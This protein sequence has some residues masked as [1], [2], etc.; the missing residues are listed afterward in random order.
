L[1]LATAS[2]TAHA[3]E[4]YPRAEAAASALRASAAIDAFLSAPAS[5]AIVRGIDGAEGEAWIAWFAG[6]AF[7]ATAANA[8][9][10]RQWSRVAEIARQRGDDE[11]YGTA[12]ARRADIAMAA[13][14]YA[15][16]EELAVTLLAL[17]RS[18]GDSAH[19]AIAEENL[20]VLER[21]RGHLDAA[22]THQLRALQLHRA[23]NDA[24]GAALALTN[25]ATLNRDRGDFAQALD[26]ALESVA[27]RERSGDRLEIA[28]RNAALLYREIE[29]AATSRSYFQRAL[30]IAARKGNPSTYSP[31]IGAYAG[32]LNDLGEFAAAQDAAGEA[33]AIDQALGDRP[34]QGLEHLELGRALIGRRQ[35]DAASDELDAALALGRELGQREIVASALLHLAD[36]ALMRHDTLHAR[37]LL[38][39][40]ISGLEAAQLRTQLAHAYASREQLARAEHNDTD[41][42]RFAH[43]HAAEREELLG[44]R[45]SRQLAALETRHAR[46]EAEQRLAL[47][48]KNNE[49]QAALLEKQRLQRRVDLGALVA[50]GALLLLLIWRFAGISRLNRALAMRNA[51]IEQQRSTLG[52]ANQ[53]LERQAIDLYQVAITD[54]MTGV[55]NRGHI[56]QRLAD[57]IVDC[58]R[59]G[60]ELSLLLIDFDHFKKINDLH[61]HAIGDSVLIAGVDAIRRCLHAD[62]LLGRIGGEEFIAIILDHDGEAVAALAER[63]RIG[64]A[65][66]LA[67]LSPALRIPATV[68]IGIARLAQLDAPAKTE[69][70]L[71]AADRALYAAKSAG[72]NRVHSYLV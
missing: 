10:D 36:L 31:V 53:R 65:G 43:K 54:S 2:T 7:S 60:R 69:A 3:G 4:V 12:L 6:N 16:C 38:D 18:S 35:F 15:R 44:V 20:G 17:A 19:A 28:Y 50:L 63:V 39:E 56:L 58:M 52:Q 33:L 32:L 70:L 49:L 37:G 66:K 25:L 40:A 13:G 1:A 57:C 42:L 45:A 23:N 59:E 5:R 14:D 34:H 64:V 24:S 71:E 11:G 46:A 62:D 47:L 9:A 26:N 27:L 22:L 41:A 51:E 21:R 30:D 72:R 68:S 55:M 67:E 8:A 61:G 29:D 48:A